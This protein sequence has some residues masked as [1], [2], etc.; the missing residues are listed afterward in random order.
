MLPQWIIEKKRDGQPLSREEIEYFVKG[1]TAG[2]IPDY[3]MSALAMAIYF[4]SM[5]IDEIRLL[6]DSMMHSGSLLDTASVEGFKCDKH[7]TGGIGDKVSLIL[8]PL[9]AACGLIVPSITGRGLGISGGTYD[10]LSSISGY[11]A[12][13]SEKRFIEVLKKCGC[14]LIGQTASLVPADKKLYAL[15]D[16]TT[17][18]PVIPLIVSSIMSKKLAEGLDGLVLDVK[19]GKGAFMRTVEQGRELAEK[20]VA[21]GKSMGKKVQALITDMNE[22]LGRCAGNALEV[23]ESL[24]IL[25]GGPGG[26]LLEIT[27]ELGAVMLELTGRFESREPAREK[28]REALRSGRGREKFL[29]MVELHG[30][31]WRT[32]E[33]PYRLPRARIIRPLVCKTN[34]YVS[35]VDAE[36]IGRGCLLLGAG[37]VLVEDKIDYAVGISQ[38][39]KSGEQVE[40]GQALMEVHACDE[41]RL[42]E[43]WPVLESAVSLSAQAPAARELFLDEI[44]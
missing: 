10:K 40:K 39:V 7:S 18:V 16:V 15:R 11:D 34:A 21:V 33:K 20:M 41:K 26:D 12:D 13:L 8:A 17:T 4:R 14:S 25:E 43:A 38:L 36:L 42:A 22:P 24:E 28:M 2:A 1:F 6:T 9:A 5:N 37:R 19:V 30:G 44:K 3:Q 32:L 31:D 29:K 35:A 23:Q 27:L